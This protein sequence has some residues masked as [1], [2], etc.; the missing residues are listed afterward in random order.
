M[1][2]T[3]IDIQQNKFRI[4]KFLWFLFG[5]SI[6]IFV[7]DFIY[8]I[9][10]RQQLFNEAPL[11][12]GL[13]L[14]LDI[15]VGI[16]VFFLTIVLSLLKK[17]S[18][19]GKITFSKVVLTCLTLPVLPVYLLISN[20]VNKNKR[21]FSRII[22]GIVPF[23]LLLPFWV[24]GYVVLYYVSTDELFLGTRYQVSSI[25]Y[26]DSMLP[27]FRPGSIGKYYP[28]KNILYKLNPNWAYKLNRGDIISFKNGITQSYLLK[29]NID[30][31]QDLAKRVIAIG[32]D[33]VELKAG[34][35]ILNG[36]P[37]E[38]P[39]TLDPNSTFALPE[40]YKWA[41][42]NGLS[43]LF[44]EECQP[45]TVPN[46]MLFVLGDNRKDSNDSRTFGFVDLKDIHGYFPYAEQKIPFKEGVNTINYSDQWRNTSNDLT[47]ALLK[48]INSYCK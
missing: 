26:S 48:K 11:A 4:I 12:Y 40:Q 45:V 36:K 47:P 10:I 31:Y 24:L 9:V 22:G 29:E 44:M 6:L 2:E 25:A 39:Y 19:R 41:K 15:V 7:V 38:E 30:S 42:Q 21:W 8:V 33:T 14:I 5:F 28:Y 3:K 17:I 34:V 13:I 46:G 18:G 1:T 23:I 43:G 16:L 35:V 27:T 20:L 32:G 37:L